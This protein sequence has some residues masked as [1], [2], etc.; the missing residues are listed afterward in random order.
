MSAFN[1]KQ[2]SKK[3]L[4]NY[5]IN[6]QTNEFISQIHQKQGSSNDKDDLESF[7]EAKQQLLEDKLSSKRSHTSLN[8]F[9]KSHSHLDTTNNIKTNNS[10]ALTEHNQSFKEG[11]IQKE[12][13]HTSQSYL[14]RGPKIG[15][16][17]NTKAGAERDSRYLRSSSKPKKQDQVDVKLK[18]TSNDVK[19]VNNDNSKV[20]R[21]FSKK[22]ESP[23]VKSAA[24]KTTKPKISSNEKDKDFGENLVTLINQTTSDL[25]AN[26]N[27]TGTSSVGVLFSN[28][29]S[30]YKPAIVESKQIKI[31]LSPT[32]CKEQT[33]EVNTFRKATK[34][35]KDEYESKTS[36]ETVTE[37]I[38]RK[39]VKIDLAVENK[40]TK[41]H[42]LMTVT[43]LN[44]KG[45]GSLEQSIDM[46]DPK[47]KNFSS[48]TLNLKKSHITLG[49]GESNNASFHKDKL[50]LTEMDDSAKTSKA[51]SIDDLNPQKHKSKLAGKY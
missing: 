47:A 23:S 18:I 39:K 13:N 33:T 35:I 19:E 2:L 51:I 4:G 15:L 31:A 24:I 34:S 16:A 14:T 5:S 8:I 6:D 42:P 37:Q 17:N 28:L 11:K 41:D 9:H 3:I 46:S 1:S 30:N 22:T 40:E 7:Y 44:E 48:K 10:I 45:E 38:T 25:K 50:N 36:R 43:D 21:S 27:T 49:A 12:K 20:K 29:P 32:N 26:N